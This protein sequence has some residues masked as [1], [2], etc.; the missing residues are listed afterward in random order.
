VKAERGKGE[1][2][3]SKNETDWVKG[4]TERPIRRDQESR[5]VTLLAK[6]ETTT[7][8]STRNRAPGRL[9]RRER[10]SPYGATK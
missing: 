3:S 4:K 5:G 10:A 7:V 2:E 8:Q 6:K 1:T 9:R